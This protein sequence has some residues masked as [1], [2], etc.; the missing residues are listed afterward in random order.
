MDRRVVDERG[1]AWYRLGA[2]PGVASITYG[3]D[4]AGSN[5]QG[6][7]P[8]LQAGH[9]SDG[10]IHVH[11]SA[12]I[13]REEHAACTRSWLH[14]G[15]VVIVLVGR[16]GDA[17]VVTPE[18]HDWN[19]ARSVGVV[20]CTEEGRRDSIGSW[21]SFWLR[22]P[23]ARAWCLEH[24]AGTA[25]ASLSVTALRDLPVPMPPAV[26]RARIQSLLNVIDEKKAVNE[27]I[28][29]CAV[30]LADAYF[31]E[32]PATDLPLDRTPLADVA[33][34]SSGLARPTQDGQSPGVGWV[35]SAEVLQS[36]FP[37]LDQVA[38]V[39]TTSS[40]HIV[41]PGS[42]LV[43]STPSGVQ[44]VETLVPVIPSRGM[45]AVSPFYESDRMW[46]LHDLRARAAELVLTAQGRQARELSRRI[47]EQ[48]TVRWPDQAM[49]EAFGR[50]AGPLHARAKLAT[51]ENHTLDAL[52]KAAWREMTPPSD[53]PPSDS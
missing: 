2:L 43:A 16:V 1:C 7:V 31:A 17:A 27:R 44:I 50:V 19:A 33:K 18:E 20:T 25:R 24:S 23:A 46:L 53:W 8:L 39:I 11:Q 10:R 36:A 49:R 32:I 5:L 9:I 30:K 37:H 48:Q 40:E 21:V 35:T 29:E 15:D 45:L 13:S 41:Q 22:S 52:A 34:V 42:L 51:A 14:A 6:G 26:D 38:R 28:A 3:V 47:F 4:R 12:F